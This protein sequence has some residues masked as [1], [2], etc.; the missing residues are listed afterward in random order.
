MSGNSVETVHAVS[1]ARISDDG[2]DDEHGVTNQHRGN[3]KVAAALG[4]IIV[5][6]LTDNDTS[7][8]KANVVRKGFER[9]VTGLVSGRLDGTGPAFSAVVVRNDDR[10]VRRAGDYERFVESL[11]SKPGRRYANARGEL[12]LYS[13][14]V[15]GMGLVAVAFAK[16]EA[17]KIQRRMREFHRDNAETGRTPGGNRPFGWA[18]DRVALDPVEAPLLAT[19]VSEFVAGR[20]LNSIVRDWN[21]RGIRT[22]TGREWTQRSLRVTI[23]NP[24]LCGFR[25]INDELING[26]DGHPVVGEWAAVVTADQWR[27]ADAIMNGRKGRRVGR[28]G[29][30]GDE[31]PHDHRE[32]RYLLGGILRCGKH[33]ADGNPCN[34]RL[35]VT[36]QRDCVQHIY[37]CPTKS[38]GGC[39]G[40]GRRGDR[41]D[42][43]ISEMVLAKLEER[44]IIATETGEWGGQEAV[45]RI[46]GKIASLRAQWKTDAISDNFFF[47]SIRELEEEQSDLRRERGRHAAMTERASADVA[48]VRRRWNLAPE[49]GGYDISQK[50]ALVREFLHAVIVLPVGRGNGSRGKFDPDKLVPIWRE[51]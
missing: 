3:R 24:R 26:A 49:D 4:W 22:A 35:R 48:D 16:I 15:E 19:A 42:E 28:D 46:E 14:T 40:L 32:H 33:R 38:Q 21:A 43:Y 41:T 27:A 37:T 8:S 5:A 18:G 10:L 31:L 44:N 51:D 50:R 2:E 29:T 23:A 20:A 1:Y 47:A 12:D 13:E 39:A 6:E 17:R 11:T 25:R 34:A 36:H 45:D 7:A 30:P 9:L